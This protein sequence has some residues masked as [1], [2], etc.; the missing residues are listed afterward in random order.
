M[1]G[2][3]SSVAAA[4]AEVGPPC[5]RLWSGHLARHRA[6]RGEVKRNCSSRRRVAVVEEL[7]ESEVVRPEFVGERVR[8]TAD[9][10][11]DDAVPRGGA[12]AH[13]LVTI[14]MLGAQLLLLIGDHRRAV[15]RGRAHPRLRPQPAAEDAARRGADARVG[16]PRRGAQLAR[17]QARRRLDQPL[18]DA[19]VARLVRVDGSSRSSSSPSSSS[20]LP[21]PTLCARLPPHPVR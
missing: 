6:A 21:V 16:D 19:V 14:P 7:R 10:R 8:S 18:G 15:R 2:R 17:L 5:S 4:G 1:L 3:A 13:A 12:R 20:T 9:G 11:A